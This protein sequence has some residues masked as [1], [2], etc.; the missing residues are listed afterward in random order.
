[1][2]IQQF[3]SIL[4]AHW[5]VAVGV[6]LL[7]LAT[8]GSLSLLLPKQYIAT[9]TVLA[10]MKADPV[11]GTDVPVQIM[12]ANYIATQV[13]VVSSDRVAGRAAAILGFEHDQSLLN[14]WQRATGGRGEFGAWVAEELRRHLQVTP[15][16]ESNVINIGFEWPVAKQAAVIANA[17]AQ[18]YIDT[19]V[20]LKVAPAKQYADWFKQRADALRN[21]VAARQR[22]LADFQSDKGILATDERVDI[23]LTRLNQLS[24]Q[25][26]E[27]QVQRE[28]SQSR[29]HPRGAAD[30]MPEVLQSPLINSLKT[31]LSAAEERLNGLSDKL[32]TSHPDYL[33]A[34][35]EIVGLRQ[36]LGEET[37]K[38]VRSLHT[39]SDVN[40]QREAA[41]RAALE[42]QKTRVLEMKHQRDEAAVLERDV[43]NAQRN[44]DAVDQRLAQTSLESQSQQTTV[45]MLT[46]AT[47]PFRH[48]SPKLRSNLLV[49]MFLGSV[50]GAAA[51]L[52]L[53]VRDKRVRSAEDLAQL[54]DLPL[55]GNIR[56]A[57]SQLISS[58][59]SAAAAPPGFYLPFQHRPD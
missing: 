33:K 28:D 25:L 2:S 15:S 12:Q 58:S 11:A 53:E 44:L 19:N 56:A 31:E 41:L 6:L 30:S 24:T 37:A 39:N 50:L 13:D 32:G 22:L 59:H 4:R 20:E 21:E 8:A 3:L 1:M 38:I 16:R 5:S 43:Q 35:A 18:A 26:G 7:A 23:E 55:L 48:S 27:V 10:E 9:A 29:Q 52:L 47:E 46:P 54:L 14:K 42:E 49:A 34:Q 57:T 36:R 45:V 40:V 17:F 51:A